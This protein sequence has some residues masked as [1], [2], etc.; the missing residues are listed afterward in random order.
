MRTYLL[1]PSRTYA[2]YQFSSGGP[3]IYYTANSEGDGSGVGL[4][5]Y[6]SDG[7]GQWGEGYQSPAMRNGDGFSFGIA[8]MCDEEETRK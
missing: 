2:L 5:G 3:S 4:G 7:D 1:V 8:V 6:L